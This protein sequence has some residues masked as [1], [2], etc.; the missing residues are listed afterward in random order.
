MSKQ[1][2][3]FKKVKTVK[4]LHDYVDKQI[5]PGAVQKIVHEMIDKTA[6]ICENEKK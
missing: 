2:K 4:E 5:W 1:D 3:E 6:C